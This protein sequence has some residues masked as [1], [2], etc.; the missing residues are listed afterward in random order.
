MFYITFI[1]TINNIKDG[2]AA[3]C[4]NLVKSTLWLLETKLYWTTHQKFLNL[5]H[6]V[7]ICSDSALICK[8][9]FYPISQQ[10]N[11]S[12]VSVELRPLSS[13]CRTR[14]TQ[15]GFVDVNWPHPTLPV[16]TCTLELRRLRYSF[17]R[18]LDS[19]KPISRIVDYRLNLKWFG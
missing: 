12:H 3:F 2:M 9:C 1:I 10:L 7:T 5:P 13:I 4:Q 6:L 18:L 8:P 17:S 14:Q 15:S 11:E 19:T 16:T